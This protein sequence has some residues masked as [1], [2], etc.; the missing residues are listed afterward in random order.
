MKRKIIVLLSALLVSAMLQAC[1]TTYNI[2]KL[3]ESDLV[4]ISMDWSISI[5]SINNQK[6][7]YNSMALPYT[8]KLPEGKY[9]LEISYSSNGASQ[10]G[11]TMFPI[12]VFKGNS[13]KISPVIQGGYVSY[14]IE[15]IEK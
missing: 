9:V 10:N 6:Y 2:N 5:Y 12:E 8:L 14:M 15:R 3:P 7:F 13:Y 11:S 4:S 1:S